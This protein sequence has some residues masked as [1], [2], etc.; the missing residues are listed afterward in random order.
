MVG[1]GE[2]RVVR[3]GVVGGRYFE[4]MGLRP[5]LGPAARADRRRP[6]CR[7][8]GG[9]DPPLLDDGAGERS[10]VLGKTSGSGRARPR[11]SAC[12]SRR[13]RIPP[14]PRSS[15]T[16]SPVRIICRRRWSTGRV[17]RMTELFGRLAP[18]ADL[19]TARAELRDGARRDRQGASRRRIRRR[20][21]SGSTR[22]RL[23][24]QITSPAQNGAAGSAR[25]VRRWSSSSPARTSRT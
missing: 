9:A 15:P 8:R 6:E 18:G 21:I 19:E 16:S 7:G 24:D 22:V 20:R 14:R 4:V 11:S 5:V 17:H 2:P 25:G 23:R 13:C 1:L 10:D 3:A 12:S